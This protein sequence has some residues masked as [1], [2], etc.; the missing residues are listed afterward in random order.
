[1]LERREIL[2]AS[3]TGKLRRMRGFR[4]LLVHEYG[5]VDDRLVYEAV[6]SRLPD[7]EAF[8]QAILG[9]LRQGE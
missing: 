3:L 8:K 7:F 4:N 1:M 5:R 9:A 6:R 2:S